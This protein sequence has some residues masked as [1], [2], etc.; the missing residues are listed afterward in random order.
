MKITDCCVTVNLSET[1]CLF[2][3]NY[4]CFWFLF[5][6]Q[7]SSLEVW[8]KSKEHDRGKWTRTPWSWGLL[9]YKR[10][11]SYFENIV[12]TRGNSTI[13]SWI[14]KFLFQLY[15]LIWVTGARLALTNEKK[16]SENYNEKSR[17]M[18]TFKTDVVQGMIIQNL[19]R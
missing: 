3:D 16:Y 5:T 4:E 15:L 2:R 6:F 13:I 19:W 9:T 10:Y 1:W 18:L 14:S 11:Y 8:I 17:I 7:F 12:F